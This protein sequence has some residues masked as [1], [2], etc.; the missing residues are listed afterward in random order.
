MNAHLQEVFLMKGLQKWLWTGLLT[1]AAS[2]AFSQ[3]RFS[4]IFVNPPL[5]GAGGDNGREFIELISDTPNYAMTDLWIVIIE[6]DGTL[7]PGTIDQALPLG[8][9]FTGSNTLFLWRDAITNLVPTPDLA[10]SIHVAD[11]TPDIENGANTFLIVS[12]F[13]GSVGQDLDADND[14]VLDFQPWTQVLDAVAWQDGNSGRVYAAQLGGVEFRDL[15][16]WTPDAY[17]LLPDGTPFVSDVSVP[18]E[19]E[20]LGPF[21]VDAVR[22]RP[23]GT[24]TADCRLTPGRSNTEVCPEPNI[25]GDVNGDGCV[26]DIDLLA[27]LFAFGSYGTNLPEDLNGDGT[28]DDA[29]LLEVLFNFGSGC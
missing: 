11:F 12:G 3:V 7:V 24:L 9:F 19:T 27:V 26:D 14:G 28:V 22:Q 18:S 4:E 10:T 15:G 2:M 17:I 21:T 13:T 20:L 23:E 1:A 8:L 25:P 5:G 29:D 6:G 16:S